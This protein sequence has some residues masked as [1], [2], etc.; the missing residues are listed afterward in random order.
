M[1]SGSKEF[2]NANFSDKLVYQMIMFYKKLGKLPSLG[3]FCHLTPS[4]RDISHAKY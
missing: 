2:L 4:I 3:P 1:Y